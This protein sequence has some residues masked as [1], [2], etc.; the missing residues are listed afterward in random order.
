MKA[1]LSV[2]EIPELDKTIDAAVK[3]RKELPT[4]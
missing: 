1:I 2:D 4:G 3:L